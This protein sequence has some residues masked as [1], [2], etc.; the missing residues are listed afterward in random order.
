MLL[1]IAAAIACVSVAVL[2]VAAELRRL[3][4]ERDNPLRTLR[5][6]TRRRKAAL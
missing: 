1:T 6:P 3:R 5:V 2:P 4:D